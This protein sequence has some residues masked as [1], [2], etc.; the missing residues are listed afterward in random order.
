ME[1][2]GKQ[3]NTQREESELTRKDMYVI[4]LHMIYVSWGIDDIV[5][6]LKA[7]NRKGMI[8]AWDD[9]HHL[10]VDGRSGRMREP[11]FLIFQEIPRDTICYK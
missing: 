4:R 6:S 11:A 1:T 5:Q 3:D 10:D 8:E 7:R 2:T 9:S